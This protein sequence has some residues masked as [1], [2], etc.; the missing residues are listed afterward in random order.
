MGQERDY[1]KRKKLGPGG[2]GGDQEQTQTEFEDKPQ[3]EDIL[4]KLNKAIKKA[5]D[6][7]RDLCGKC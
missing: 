3:V 5:K 6:R 1:K 7:Q 4:K 2:E